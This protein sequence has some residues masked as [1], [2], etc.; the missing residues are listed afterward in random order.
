[1]CRIVRFE[2]FLAEWPQAE[3]G[4]AHVNL[5][6]A[7]VDDA[8]LDLTLAVLDSLLDGA[9]WPARFGL[10]PAFYSDCDRDEMTATRAFLREYRELP[11]EQ[12]GHEPGDSLCPF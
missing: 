3:F 9:P 6:D 11:E 12:R 8:D 1:M 4:P 10:T 2:P 7:N 5:S